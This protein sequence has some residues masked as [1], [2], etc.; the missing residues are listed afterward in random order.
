V[1]TTV[2]N[3]R[4]LQQF[5]ETIY[6]RLHYQLSEGAA[7]Q[8]QVAIRMLDRF[9]GR[10]V[11]LDELSPSLLA[12]YLHWL[13]QDRKNSA[14]TVNHRRSAI[15]TLWWAAADEGLCPEPSLRKLPRPMRAPKRLPRAWTIDQIERILAECM[16]LSG[17]LP[18]SGIP[19]DQFWVSLTLYLYDSGSRIGAALDV[20]PLDVDLEA[21]VITLRADHAKTELEQFVVLSAQTVEWIAKHYD[22]ARLRLWPWGQHRNELYRTLKRILIRAG[23]PADRWSMFHRFRRTTATLLTKHASLSVAQQALGHTT[24]QMTL[25]YVD[26]RLLNAGQAAEIL[27]R[28]RVG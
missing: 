3:P 5:Y 15:I 16:R 27:P 13:V 24:P 12:E 25:K 8:Y 23:L 28:P 20:S 26:P 21:R 9:A 2:S 11:T 14:A 1:E 22:P 19:R 17:T 6:L 4:A 7:H 10:P 18:L